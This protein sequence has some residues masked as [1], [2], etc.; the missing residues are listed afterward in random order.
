MEEIYEIITDIIDV[1]LVII[2]F[3][4]CFAFALFTMPLHWIEVSIFGSFNV[5]KAA[6]SA[7]TWMVYN[8]PMTT[9]SGKAVMIE[10]GNAIEKEFHF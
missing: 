2:W 1:I 3:I 7:I 8:W 4:I 6:A 9:N 5:T 10:I